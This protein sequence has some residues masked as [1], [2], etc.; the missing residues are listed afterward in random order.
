[1]AIE[2]FG[3]G[4]YGCVLTP[5]CESLRGEK[6]LCVKEVGVHQG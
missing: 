2:S 1:M 3:K 4:S 6:A 5:V